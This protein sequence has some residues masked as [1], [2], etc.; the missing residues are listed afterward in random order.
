MNIQDTLRANGWV[1]DNTE[2]EWKR[3]GE[4]GWL[5]RYQ[6]LTQLAQD[7]HARI[8][9][10]GAQLKEESDEA[11][12]LFTF[13][14]DQHARIAELEASAKERVEQYLVVVDERNAAN[15][16]LV[17]QERRI[18]AYERGARDHLDVVAELQDTH[19][20][21][22]ELEAQAK[23]A[24]T[25]YALGDDDTPHPWF[26]MFHALSNR[27]FQ[28]VA[29]IMTAAHESGLELVP[30][31]SLVAANARAGAAEKAR[32]TA[33]RG[34]DNA[35][36]A[37]AKDDGSV[38]GILTERDKLAARVK[39][40]E[41]DNPWQSLFPQAQA[42]WDKLKAALTAANERADAAE[43][44][45][46][47]AKA[48]SSHKAQLLNELAARV[49]ELEASTPKPYSFQIRFDGPPGPIAGRFVE[50]ETLEGKGLSVGHWK[51]D[52]DDW[53]L[54]VEGYDPPNQCTPAERKVLGAMG[55]ISDE[56]LVYWRDDIPMH[57]GDVAKA[58]LSLAELA[59]RASKAK[60]KREAT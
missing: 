40:L 29:C 51:Q 18:A 57:E 6:A 49:K 53:L 14:E 4:I 47:L 8:A 31:G 41:A 33:Q 48:A 12:A 16:K 56:T 59:N 21:I 44:S 28:T 17:Q 52:D 50:C 23:I 45:L 7:Q 9:E 32:D 60:A 35:L 24:V 13:A 25:A 2:Q 54:V 30:K 26:P 46:S 38:A 58:L 20:R 15:A 34:F 55:G 39:E 3:D 1:S 37:L 5:S 27:L 22:A 19:A 42:E 10:L 11:D 36:R 43:R